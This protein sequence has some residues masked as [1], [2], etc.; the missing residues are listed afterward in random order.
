MITCGSLAS[1]HGQASSCF[2]TSP[3]HM[4]QHTP[5]PILLGRGPRGYFPR[6]LDE[7]ANPLS[8][9][10]QSKVME[11]QRK[12]LEP[13]H[14]APGRQD[15][16]TCKRPLALA[17]LASQL[18]SLPAATAPFGSSQPQKY[19]TT[20]TATPSSAAPLRLA[21]ALGL[22]AAPS[23]TASAATKAPSS[24]R[25]SDGE[26]A[27]SSPTARGD[28]DDVDAFIFG[29]T[30]RVAG[31]TELGLATRVPR[32]P[33]TGK[34]ALYL[35]IDSVLP[36]G[37]VE[38]WNRQCGSSGAPEKVLLA[39]DKIIRVNGAWDTEAMLREFETCRL[40]RMLIVRTPGEGIAAEEKPPS[41]QP[42]RVE[43]HKSLLLAAAPFPQ[44]VPTRAPQP[45]FE[46]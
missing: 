10:Q 1:N 20:S 32:D 3:H 19:V 9:Q 25:L 45:L 46:L 18:S 12:Q 8:H 39:G 22:A 41:P 26:T 13:V 35:R 6:G 31:G 24:S 29:F 43:L 17:E 16:A 36:G 2:G 23:P 42:Q 28:E 40:L 5:G 7:K 27:S 38:A 15:A 4:A 21:D 44:A 14:V 30:I 11:A 33:L 37:A 34:D